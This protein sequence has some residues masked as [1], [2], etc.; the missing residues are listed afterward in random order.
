VSTAWQN[1][2]QPFHMRMKQYLSISYC[3]FLGYDSVPCRDVCEGGYRSVRGEHGASTFSPVPID[4]REH[5]TMTHKTKIYILIMETSNCIYLTTLSIARAKGCR[6][7][8]RIL[9]G[10]G[11]LFS[12]PQRPDL[13]WGPHSL[14]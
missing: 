2:F 7:R 11:F 8:V 6:A 4:K 1:K 13:S 9:A 5:D 3:S 10:V 14:L 12:S